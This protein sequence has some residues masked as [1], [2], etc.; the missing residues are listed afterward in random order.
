MMGLKPGM[1]GLDAGCGLG[2]PSRDLV[3]FVDVHITGVSIN[4]IHVDRATE[5]AKAEQLEGRLEYVE[6][7]FM[8]GHL[9][10]VSP[11]RGCSCTAG[12][13][14]VRRRHIRLRLRD[15]G[16]RVRS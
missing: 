2:A 4:K 11:A 14:H 7:D 13:K 10:I 8:V 5:Q 16:H 12:P 9:M 6:G 15:G 3:R 1:R